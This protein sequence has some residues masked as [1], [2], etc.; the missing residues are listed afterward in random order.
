MRMTRTK[1]RKRG[2]D[3]KREGD[4]ERET[5]SLPEVSVAESDS[6]SSSPTKGKM[7]QQTG[8]QVTATPDP[9]H[10]PS[11]LSV[12]EAVADY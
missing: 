9:G 5:M 3:R 2:P 10:P 4:A 6:L 7:P 11:S 12:A 8:S 1:K